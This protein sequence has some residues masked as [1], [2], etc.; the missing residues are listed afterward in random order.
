MKA[1]HKP[2]LD[3]LRKVSCCAS[4]DDSAL[5]LLQEEM[6]EQLFEDGAILCREDEPGDCMFIIESG[7][8]VVMKRS[9]E[10]VSVEI[11]ALGE[12]EIA[13][14]LSLLGEEV[15]SATLKARGPVRAWV[16]EH[17]TFQTLLDEHGALARGVLKCLSRNLARGTS[18]MA[19]LLAR[20]VD[21][22]FKVAVFDA[23]PYMTSSLQERNCHDYALQFYEFRLSA[24]TVAM[25]AGFDA[26][27]VFVNDS[28]DADVVR[29]L[30]G[31]GVGMIALR[32]AGFNNVDVAL[33]A[34]LG[35]SVARVPA[36]SP[37]AV[38][39]H[40]VALM[41]TLNRRVHR[42]H[43]RVREGNFSLDGLVG[44]DMH[45]K[46]AG[47]VGT[48]KIGRCLVSILKGFGCR[49]LAFDKF[50][51]TTLADSL[52]VEYVELPQLFAESDVISLHAPLTPETEHMID[53]AAIGRM[54]DGVMLINTSR[55]ALVDTRALLDGL[56]SGRIGYAGLDVYE[57]EGGY[58][59]EDFSDRVITDDVL[60][61]LTTFNNVVVT[62]HQAFLTQDALNNIADTT[63]AN[64]REYEQGK[65]CG[66][67]GNAVL[68]APP[69]G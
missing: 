64:L 69:S 1:N 55:G 67:L 46:T 58:F 11:T 33:C 27:C 8:V 15:R 37:Y 9:P 47:V 20:D 39:E 10:G 34:E 12:G 48:G 5:R 66:E 63:F 52:G 65:R 59:F 32:C 17:D 25:A 13:G 16:L 19:K 21:N 50:P 18:V 38:A 57:E 41:M 6:S 62:S 53:A 22:R 43:S 60:A 61:R 56:K 7:E 54:K 2:D 49:L 42:A 36:Y 31:L 35:V 51:D 23:K 68:P 26:V 24:D 45:G 4:L 30:N 3:V 28:L 44:F 14:E 29:E 40:A